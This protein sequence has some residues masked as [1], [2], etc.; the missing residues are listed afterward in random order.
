MNIENAF[1]RRT[2][3]VALAVFIGGVALVLFNLYRVHFPNRE[4]AMIPPLQDMQTFCVGRYQIDLPRGSVLYRAISSAGGAASADF[5]AVQP[6]PRHE[7]ENTV[8][9]RWV[10]IQKLKLDAL[11]QPFTQPAE[12][13]ELSS[14]TILFTFNHI[15]RSGRWPGGVT[16]TKSFYDTEG[17][18]WRN[19][20]LYRFS[21]GSVEDRVSAAMRRLQPHSNTDIPNAQGFCAGHSFFPGAPEDGES[22]DFAFHLPTNPPVELRIGTMGGDFV[23]QDPSMFD[24]ADLK[25]SFVRDTHRGIGDLA[26]DEWIYFDASRRGHID[27]YGLGAYW[28]R[29]AGASI[30]R[31]PSINV[32]M[33]IDIK[34]ESSSSF[35]RDFPPKKAEGDIGKEEFLALWDGILK[36]L[37]PRPGAF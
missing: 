30:S 25:M 29:P 21:G 7:F 4:H 36:T 1:L 31:Q 5:S 13:T 20:T 10:A 23:K 14:D 33:N 18:L 28:H 22:T 16:G 37:R 24:M 6:V 12:R 9:E 8:H 2:A 32:Q 26:G 17:Y 11:G 27:T 35:L 19:E 15:T 34:D 3:K